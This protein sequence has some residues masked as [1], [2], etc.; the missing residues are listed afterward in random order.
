MRRTIHETSRWA[1]LGLAGFLLQ[2]WFHGLQIDGWWWRV[3]VAALFAAIVLFL[4]TWDPLTTRVAKAIPYR[5]VN[6]RGFEAIQSAPIQVRQEARRV[7]DEQ[8]AGVL[9]A[10]VL[11]VV[12]ELNAARQDI[13]EALMLGSYWSDYLGTETWDNVRASLV[14]ERGIQSAYEL[15]RDAYRA[16]VKAN[17]RLYNAMEALDLSL[18]RRHDVSFFRETVTK[19]KAAES[20]LKAFLLGR[21]F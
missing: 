15:T 10:N 20:A 16:I 4:G 8:K 17:Q 14:Q 5:V 18:E 11:L 3:M 7:V 21:D 6:T 1:G 9:R 2:D 13:D 19:I 12:D